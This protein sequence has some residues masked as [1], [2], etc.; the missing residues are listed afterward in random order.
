NGIAVNDRPV[1]FERLNDRDQLKVGTF[2][3]RV[4]YTAET[5]GEPAAVESVP[6][7]APEAPAT[8][9]PGPEFWDE[10]AARSD[11]TIRELESLRLELEARSE[12]IREEKETLERTRLEIQNL[13]SEAQ[14]AREAE[15]DKLREESQREQESLAA[16]RDALNAERTLLDDE[17]QS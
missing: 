13:R 15:L 11:E 5:L 4:R 10:Q 1:R 2:V 7:Q 8:H 17:R 3:L 12:R 16:M 6:Q 9:P 14:R